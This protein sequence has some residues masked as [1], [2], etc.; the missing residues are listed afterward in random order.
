MREPNAEA[1]LRPWT[2][3]EL[4]TALDDTWTSLIGLCHEL[5]P[6]EWALDTGCPGWT[7]QDQVAHVA[8]L[9][10]VLSGAPVPD[11]E[12]PA[13]LPH[14]RDEL[15]RRMEVLVDFRRSRPPEQVVA[16]LE[17][18]VAT[19]REQ[20]RAV[21]PDTVLPSAFGT[22]WPAIRSLPIRV[23]DCFA[24]EQDVRRATGR[25]GHLAGPA[26]EVATVQILRGWAALAPHRNSTLV[27]TV[28]QVG[29]VDLGVTFDLDLTGD[30]GRLVPAG[31]VPEVGP[32]AVL[33]LGTEALLAH[34]GG[35]SD[36]G[37]YPVQIEGDVV[38]GQSLLEAGGITP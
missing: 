5:E 37:S 20:L 32:R 16:E 26:A 9:E 33:T 28:V 34:G 30:Q 8:G 3:D 15:G 24:H 18:V 6:R 35:R 38:L 17:E 14:V 13:D 23:V 10:S 12:L 1:L 2:I 11:H 25:S 31:G 27:G 36:A 4:R 7:V 21:S 22:G 19:R 29:C